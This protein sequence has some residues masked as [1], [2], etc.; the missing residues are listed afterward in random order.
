MRQ[1]LVLTLTLAVS[2][3]ALAQNI[4]T[5][6]FDIYAGYQ[7]TRVGIGAAQDGLNALTDPFNL[8]RIDLGRSL[9]LNGGNA[10]FQENI[11]SWFGG[12]V[13]FSGSMTNKKVDLSKQ[14]QALGLVAPGT[15]VTA[16][17]KPTLYTITGGPQFTYRKHEHFQPFA[18]VLLGVARANLAPNSTTSA[19]IDSFTTSLALPHFNT[20]RNSFAWMGGAGTDYVLKRWLALRASVDYQRTYLFSGIKVPIPGNPDFHLPDEHQG[21]F[22]ISAGVSFRLHPW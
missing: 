1:R 19:A 16:G 17:F 21:N 15:T 22:R 9:N 3:F 10:S 7:Y 14:A 12:I 18:R 5:P 8:P 2:T 20:T 4:E 11:N 6:R 13:D